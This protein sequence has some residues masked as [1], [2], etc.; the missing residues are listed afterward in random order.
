[1]KLDE[2][3]GGGAAA[4]VG[5]AL[6]QLHDQGV[7]PQVI[8]DH[9]TLCMKLI[10]AG[11]DITIEDDEIEF[12]MPFFNIAMLLNRHASGFEFIFLT[13]VENIVYDLH[14]GI[15]A[16][17]DKTTV[18]QAANIDWDKLNKDLHAASQLS[19]YLTKAFAR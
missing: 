10:K 1:M 17:I 3:S 15:N 8:A 11:A 2:V 9:Q 18:K 6:Q 12:A 13:D 14:D 19:D 7:D 4:D 5:E 16:L